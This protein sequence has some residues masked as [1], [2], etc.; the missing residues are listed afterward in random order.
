MRKELKALEVIV[1]KEAENIKGC[2]NVGR[3]SIPLLKPVELK[4]GY[5]SRFSVGRVKVNVEVVKDCKIVRFRFSE[6]YVDDAAI[7]HSSRDGFVSLENCIPLTALSSEVLEEMAKNAG[8]GQD[9]D[10]MPLEGFKGNVESY[11]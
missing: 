6:A 3:T 1:E 2:G 11:M 7:R 5:K 8:K 10:A 4:K 9:I